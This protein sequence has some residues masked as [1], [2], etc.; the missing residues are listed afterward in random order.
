MSIIKEILFRGSRLSEVGTL[1]KSIPI[2]EDLTSREL[3]IVE[4]IAHRR[5]YGQGEAIFH[6]GDPGVGIYVVQEGEICILSENPNTVLGELS[7]GEFF[8]EIAILNETP[9]SATARAKTTSVV[10]AFFKEDLFQIIRDNPRMGVKILSS[11]ASL[12]GRRLIVANGQIEAYRRR[13]VQLENTSGKPGG[14]TIGI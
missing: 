9:R 3:S 13:I 6:E 10:L 4:R 11:L 8:G 2:F 5:S 14:S 1:L 12:A 7:S